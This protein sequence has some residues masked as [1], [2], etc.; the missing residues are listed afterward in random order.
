MA[1]SPEEL[2]ELR[3]A[4]ALLEHPGFAARL[5]ALVGSPVEK[6]LGMLPPPAAAA[7]RDATRKAIEKALDAALT[8]LNPLQMGR[9]PATRVHRLLTGVSGAAGG[10]FGA[11]G[12]VVEL[13]LTTT[14]MLRAIA[15]IA[16]SQGEDLGRIEGRLACLEVFAL[17]GPGSAD[18]AA[19][20]GY[21]AVRAA[22]ANSVSEAA[23]FIGRQG[24][25]EAGSPALVQLVSRIAARF[26]V[27]VS[28]KV[29]AQ[30]VPAVGALGGATVNL[31]FTAHFQDMAQGH[32][33]VRKLERR[34]G[35]EA[36]RAA[37]RR[38]R[39]GG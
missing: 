6:A 14:L 1:L 39:E 36:V 12:L 23:R 33:T 25:S 31:L 27:T 26:G 29:A 20:T 32:F 5:T 21:Y 16:R 18:D 28:Q 35:P 7:V 30:L 10:F 34:H 24:L 8:T 11:P 13:P 4:V 22:L 9:P 38:L 2:A 37:Y 3:R 17:G 15:D 19:E